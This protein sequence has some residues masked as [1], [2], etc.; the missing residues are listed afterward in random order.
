M[1]YSCNSDLRVPVVWIMI[2]KF[3]NM[4]LLTFNGEN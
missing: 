1:S 2:E 3:E 4:K